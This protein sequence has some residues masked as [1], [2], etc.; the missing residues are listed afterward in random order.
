MGL[1]LTKVWLLRIFF[2][3]QYENLLDWK[4]L[5]SLKSFKSLKTEKILREEFAQYPEI[6]VQDPPSLFFTDSSEKLGSV[7][8]SPISTSEC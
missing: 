5:K 1:A 6:F 3:T 2:S 4:L 8:S 7:S